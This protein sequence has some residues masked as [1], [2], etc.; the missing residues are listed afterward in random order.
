MGPWSPVPG[1]GDFCI[2]FALTPVPGLLAPGAHC[3][4][5]PLAFFPDAAAPLCFSVTLLSFPRSG[6]P[7][8]AIWGRVTFPVYVSK[9]L[10]GCEIDQ[11]CIKINFY[12]VTDYSLPGGTSN[13]LF[14]W[15][16]EAWL[17]PWGPFPTPSSPWLSSLISLGWASAPLLEGI[18]AGV[19][20]HGNPSKI[21]LKIASYVS[22][23]SFL[24]GVAGLVL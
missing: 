7:N 15:G 22:G 9:Y 12:G 4:L 2:D 14:I 10:R 20:G 18:L 17:G 1:Q 24:I 8:T 16:P 11:T 3:G 13:S 6:Q 5:R 23:P 19:H 21:G